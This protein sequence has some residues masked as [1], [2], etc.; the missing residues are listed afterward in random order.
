MS[1]KDDVF[2]WISIAMSIKPADDSPQTVATMWHIT[3]GDGVSIDIF[4]QA[5][6]PR[7]P[8]PGNDGWLS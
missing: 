2:H 5:M 3:G 1:I 6:P 7:R 8:G 4:F